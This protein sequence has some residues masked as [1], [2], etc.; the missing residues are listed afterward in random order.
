MV[1]M[2]VLK[3]LGMLMIIIGHSRCSFP[4]YEL[5]YS[6]HVPLFFLISGYFFSQKYKWS[7]VFSKCS[8]QLI[9]PYIVVALVT[10]IV[11]WLIGG[12]YV[13]IK[14]KEH[15][16]GATIPNEY[17]IGLGPIWFFLALFFCR[18]FY[19]IITIRVPNTG[20]RTLFVVIISLMV[21]IVNNYY[22]LNNIPYQISQGITSLIY[23]HTGY[24]L[25][26]YKNQ[27]EISRYS[28]HRWIIIPAALI[29]FLLCLFKY[30]IGSQCMNFSA[31]VFP[32]FPLDFL[33]AILLTVSLF[34]VVKYWVKKRGKSKTIELL[35]WIGAN[36][37]VIYSIHCLEYNFTIHP[38]AVFID[39]C[40]AKCN[41]VVYMLM[42]FINPVVH[43][44]ICLLGLW[45]YLK[46]KMIFEQIRKKE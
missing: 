20:S 31:L 38:L 23:Y 40:F 30:E 12:E 42:R 19:R 17:N 33:N 43:I 5:F 36:S 7:E 24:M 44:I 46:G 34:I 45:L 26:C 41:I 13:G 16:I 35:A 32:C 25:A 18:V 29:V 3:G 9:L 1:E 10:C 39:S 8:K 15:L 27:I 4:M 14:V 28:K 6:F 21:V 2:D 37:L 22:T 11:Y